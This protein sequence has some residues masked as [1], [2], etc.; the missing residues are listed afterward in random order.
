MTAA[1]GVLILAAMAL[2]LL[3]IDHYRGKHAHH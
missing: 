3:A 1:V 2:I